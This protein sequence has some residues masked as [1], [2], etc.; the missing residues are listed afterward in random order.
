MTRSLAFKLVLAFLLVSVAGGALAALFARWAT[1]REFEQLVLEQA[2][3]NF[4][5]SAVAYYRANGSWQGVQEY[6]RL[7]AA[8][9]QQPQSA[10]SQPGDGQRP[11]QRFPPYVFALVD[12]NGIVV[13]AAG[14]YP[15][16]QHVPA[17]ELAQGVQIEIDG[18]VMGTALVTGETPPLA[19]QEVRYLARTNRASLYAA[20]AAVLIALVLG[21]FLA[22]SLTRPVRELTA[23]TQ[24][25]AQGELGQQ[26][27]IRSHDE[28]GR[29]AA[30][31]NQMSADLALANELRRQMTADIA[32][33]LRSPLTVM[34]GYL[35]ALRDGVLQPSA[36][37]FETMHQEAL[38]LRRL[39]EDLRT[40]SLAD[41][42]EL[43]LN[44]EIVPP[45]LVLEQAAAAYQHQAGQQGIDLSVQIGSPLPRI[46]V[47]PDRVA[48]VLGNLVSNALRYTPPGGR[49]SLGATQQES[50]VLL[51]VQD[52]GDGIPPDELSH[53]FER[54]YRGDAARQESGEGSGLGLTIAK[55]IV[56]L[57]NGTISVKSILGQGTTFTIV[58]PVDSDGQ[59]T[60]EEARQGTNRRQPLWAK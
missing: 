45:A 41:S 18:Q 6:F 38:H 31:F 50:H 1:Y 58:L 33:D 5:D 9:A 40:L 20:L 51:T 15:P 35:E 54:F 3:S 56:E 2:Q 44:R 37:R 57:H 42:G 28:L 4:L 11:V 14:P 47:D 34:A 59:D 22:R 21:I 48:Q 36:E 27:P 55:S 8:G 7:A 24:A 26:V 12:T 13:M 52:T 16:G 53:V 10:S 39:V 19:S 60:S 23:A 29:L 43:T 30:S 46:T 25:M 17:A 32:H 49:I